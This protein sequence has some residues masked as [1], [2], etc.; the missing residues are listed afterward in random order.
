MK[1]NEFEDPE[2]EKFWRTHPK[3]SWAEFHVRF[4]QAKLPHPRSHWWQ[5]GPVPE[6]MPW[7]ENE[8]FGFRVLATWVYDMARG[9]YY[10][11]GAW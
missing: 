3:A 4:P 1:F 7:W 9:I 6:E 2:V 5:E 11:P 8:L 10:W